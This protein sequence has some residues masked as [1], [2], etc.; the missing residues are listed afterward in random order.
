MNEKDLKEFLALLKKEVKRKITK[1]EA[2]AFLKT[3]G[4]LTKK[5][6]VAKPYK[7]ICSFPKRA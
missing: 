4:I 6:N 3:A 1:E 7:D 2:V 5:G